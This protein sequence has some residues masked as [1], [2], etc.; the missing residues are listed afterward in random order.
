MIRPDSIWDDDNTPDT[1]VP[2]LVDR[3]GN[4][5]GRRQR[6]S[7][8]SRHR[9]AGRVA[10]AAIL[11]AVIALTVFA[12][13]TTPPED[14]HH[15]NGRTPPASISTAAPL[16]DPH[17]TDRCR[18]SRA[19]LSVSGTWP[20]GTESGPDAIL[21]FNRAYYVERSATHAQQLLAPGASG[22]NRQRGERYPLTVE[23]LQ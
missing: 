22:V 14:N 16:V 19:G 18:Q 1:S 6:R 4:N 11:T 7:T 13:A 10:G 20:G 21:A 12:I 15:P 23:F 17:A 8:P 3:T 9:V 2:R 5:P